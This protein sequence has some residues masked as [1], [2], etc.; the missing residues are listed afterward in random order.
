MADSPDVPRAW[1][2]I[3]L[4]CY[5]AHAVELL[6]RFPAANLLWSCN[7]ASLLVVVGLLARLP[8]ANAAGCFMF[9]PGNLFWILD[10]LAG[11]ELLPTSPLTHVLVFAL[12]IA[13]VRRMGVPPATWWTMVLGIAAATAA[14]R[15]VGP[16]SENVNLAFRIP[17]GWEW[18][19]PSHG[20]YML[21]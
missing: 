9:I 12:S 13:G 21:A 7:V 17:K 3:A 6:A 16:E 15:L 19:W 4:A 5:L 18:R 2:W 10:L 20:V 11:S 14:A 8:L 1:G